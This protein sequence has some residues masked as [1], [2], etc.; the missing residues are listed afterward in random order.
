MGA[1]NP[2]CK[3][4]EIRHFNCHATCPDYAKFKRLKDEENKRRHAAVE[5]IEFQKASSK[6]FR[7][8]NRKYHEKR[9]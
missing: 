8:Q 2:P 4:C 6:R 9:K 7:E 3:G 5:F 1:N